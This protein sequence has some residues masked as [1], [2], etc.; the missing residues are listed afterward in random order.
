MWHRRRRRRLGLVTEHRK[1]L[2]KNLA[3]G[4][5]EHGRIQTTYCRAKETAR[6]ADKLITVAKKGTPHAR[7]QLISQLTSPVAAK[8]L[9]EEIAPLFKDTKGGYTRV[10]RK[11]GFRAGDG[12]Q[13]AFVEFTKM[14]EKPVVKSEG[15]K[16]K[17]KKVASAETAEKE[18]SVKPVTKKAEP[19]AE[20]KKKPAAE[21]KET[22][23]SK[24]A[25]AE[26]KKGEATPGQEEPKKGGFLNNLR[27]FL[28]GD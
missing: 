28:T 24:A 3:L 1:A 23:K 19:K 6:V 22:K 7:R 16:D 8:K 10:I 13:M 21:E 9:V 5:V 20:T 15:K 26:E 14:I 18:K 11:G 4:L 17:K 2:L 12:A 27:K 25:D